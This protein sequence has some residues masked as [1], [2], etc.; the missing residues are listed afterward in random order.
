[1]TTPLVCLI[2]DEED[3]AQLINFNLEKAGY[4]TDWSESGD[5]GLERIRQKKP[6][7]ILLDLML[8]KISGIKICEQLKQDAATAK[9]PI[10]MVSAKGSELDIV[11][12]LEAG[13]DDY[14]TKPFSPHVLMARVKSVLRRLEKKE[15]HDDSCQIEGLR[16]DGKRR[17][18]Y[19]SDTKI[20]LTYSEFEI[21]RFLAKRP[22]WVFTRTQIVDAIRGQNYAVTD[23]SIDV[24]LVGLR[25]KLGASGDLIETIRGVGY[26]FR[27][28]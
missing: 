4:Q 19:I 5:K 21:L 23:R 17:E 24:V 12:G 6:D 25:K 26:R 16:I 22:G 13:A 20:D 8:P 2:E 9:I 10:I 18:V 28:V 7:L 11:Q 27:E 1:M 15:G 3:I 14:V